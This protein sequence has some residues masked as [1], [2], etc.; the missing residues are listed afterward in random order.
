MGSRT[1]GPVVLDAGGLI[2]VERGDRRVLALLS[3]ASQVVVP[4]GVVAQIWRGAARQARTARVVN[5]PET[6]VEPLDDGTARVVGVLC[7]VTGTTDVV[8]ASVALAG[9][10]HGAVVVTSDPDDLA[11]LDRDLDLH[12]C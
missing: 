10:R 11:A 4:A 3:E 1:P 6:V 8:D 5:A 12:R 7:G 2:A 9:R